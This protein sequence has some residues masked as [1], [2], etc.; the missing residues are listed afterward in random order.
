[1]GDGGYF[2]LLKSLVIT[3]EL[4]RY[5]KELKKRV[6]SA[7]IA[8]PDIPFKSQLDGWLSG[9]MC[10]VL[11]RFDHPFSKTAIFD[12]RLSVLVFCFVFQKFVS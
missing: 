10:V 7:P 6:V 5:G 3:N 1:M 9:N 2:E 11:H 8:C 12:T 4:S